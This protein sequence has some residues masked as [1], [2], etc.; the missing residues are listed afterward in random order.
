MGIHGG[1][2]G[3]DPRWLVLLA[4]ILWGTTGTAQA[5]AP[6]G[7]HPLTVGAVRL[8]V[9]GAAL[10]AIALLKGSLRGA[11]SWPVI[12][13]GLAAGCMAAYQLFFFA[14]VLKTGVAVGTVVT[15]GSSP[16][17]AGLLA[18]LFRGERPGLR[19]AMATVMAV[20]GCVLL[21][22]SGSSLNVNSLGILLALGAGTSYAAY[23]TVSKRLLD[24]Y[25][26]EAVVAVVFCLGALLLS[27]FLFYADLHWLVQVKGFFVAL[28]LGLIATALAYVFFARGLAKIPVATAVTLSLAEPLTAAF[29]GIVVLGERPSLPVFGGMLLVLAGLVIISYTPA[30]S[31]PADSQ[32]PAI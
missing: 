9:G 28:H 12:A 11:K 32:E 2:K 5:F 1:E 19:W 14:A 13:T 18:F 17:I 7:A 21:S 31:S 4:A 15:I 30:S 20:V 23:A 3:I 24:Q 10:M 8:A 6:A 29:L 25:P 27:P 16:V 22:A 26:P